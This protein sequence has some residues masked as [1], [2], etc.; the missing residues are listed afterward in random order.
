MGFWMGQ[1]KLLIERFP[2]IQCSFEA[3]MIKDVLSCLLAHGSSPLNRSMHQLE[4]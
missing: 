3:E 2:T 4:H 1:K